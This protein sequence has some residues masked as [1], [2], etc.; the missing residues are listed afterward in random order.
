MI[1]TSPHVLISFCLQLNQE[2]WVLKTVIDEES[3][4]S[5][6]KPKKKKNASQKSSKRKR[7]DTKED[8][9]EDE[10]SVVVVEDQEESDAILPYEALVVIPQ[11][12]ILV[13][14]MNARIYLQNQF[15]LKLD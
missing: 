9:E 1:W 14:I 13:L 4:K 6:K 11:T 10:Q 5:S 7:V 3:G 2:N 8:V 15:M 12:G